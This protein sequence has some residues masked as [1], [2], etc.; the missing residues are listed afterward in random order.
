MKS[1]ALLLACASLLALGAAEIL[2]RALDLPHF[3]ACDTTADYAIRDPELGFRGGP[4]DLVAGV[5]LNE[6]GWRGPPLAAPKPEG[7]RRI[8]FL[9]DSTCWGLRVELAETFAAR[10]A[11]ALESEFVLGA[12]PGYSS[13]H[14]AIVLERL[15]PLEP[16]VVVLYVGARNDGV[17]ARYFPDAD[18]PERRARLDATWHQVRLLRLVEVAVDRF[19]RSVFR[20]LLNRETRSRVPPE[21]FRANLERMLR[22]LEEAGI[23]GVLV[24]PPLSPAFEAEQ[25]QMQ[26]YREILAE[27]AAAHGLPTVSV[28]DRFAAAAA[29]SL[30]FDDHYHLRARGHEIIG[31]ELTKILSKP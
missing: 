22:R 30:Y 24:I 11:G 29:S 13:Y 31:E 16:D 15:L 12:F 2:L 28:D 18:I 21:A 5:R 23:P 19:Y 26:R 27:I 6:Q 7:E 25:P 3:D 20:K 10:T 1:R 4:G 9:G 8:L 14:S 17:R